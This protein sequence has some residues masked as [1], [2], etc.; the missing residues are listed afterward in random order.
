MK[1]NTAVRFAAARAFTLIELLVVIAIIAILAAMLLPALA[2]A[3]AKANKIACVNN[4][5]Q[6]MIAVHM[7][8]NDNRDKLP[9]LKALP[10]SYPPQYIPPGNWC[11]DL[12]VIF[13]DKL[14]EAG[15]KQDVFF[16]AANKEFNTTNTWNFG[17]TPP[18]NGFRITGYVWLMN[19]I[20]QL[21]TNVV[22]T[23]RSLAGDSRHPPSTTEYIVDVVI[24]LNGSYANVPVGG[25]PASVRQRTSHL[26]GGRPDG[27]NI[28]F[29]DA[30]V[31]W[32][33]FRNMTNSFGNP[34]FQF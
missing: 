14:I 20:P 16:C 21:P 23:P 9:D 2:K 8:A 29:L 12:P 7:Y 26:N 34:R 33:Q 6:L 24:S 17:F 30:H 4:Q 31:E 5:R 13:V 11:W 19:G 28:A 25:L 3:K 10:F 27:G 18:N 22:Y 32:R 1:K 15:A